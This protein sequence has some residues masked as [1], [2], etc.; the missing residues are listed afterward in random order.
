MACRYHEVC[1]SVQ[2]YFWCRSVEVVPGSCLCEELAFGVTPAGISGR[3][4]HDVDG[5]RLQD[6]GEPG[7]VGWTVRLYRNGALFTT[8]KTK[9]PLGYYFFPYENASPTDTFKVCV[10]ASMFTYRQTHDLDFPSSPNC[11]PSFTMPAGRRNDVDFGYQQ[12]SCLNGHV[13]HDLDADGIREDDAEPGLSGWSVRLR[14]PNG[15]I[16]TTATVAD[17]TYRFD[18]LDPGAYEVCVEP[19]AGYLPTSDPDTPPLPSPHCAAVTLEAAKCPV[20]D[21]G[22]SKLASIGGRVLHDADADGQQDY[23]ERGITGLPVTLV[24]GAGSPVATTVTDT[25]GDYSFPDL[26]VGTYAV[27]IPAPVG[28]RF[29]WDA[30]GPS[31]AGCVTVSVTSGQ[32]R[33]D[34]DFGYQKDENP[35]AIGSG[36]IRTVT[37]SRTCARSACRAWWSP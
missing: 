6:P 34:V 21:F 26:R 35:S 13:W 20:G 31:V 36:S 15:S 37:A 2:A 18:R 17:G 4:W 30:D 33:R 3:V 5:D 29:V 9:T 10:S 11:S 19:Q 24:D 7:F 32:N 27:C 1:T 8:V 14:R 23:A 12:R 16:L 28:Y 22:Y 25:M